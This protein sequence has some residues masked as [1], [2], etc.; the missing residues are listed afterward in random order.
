MASNKNNVDVI[1][2]DEGKG[3]IAGS[4][5]IKTSEE[6]AEPRRFKKDDMISCRSVTYGELLFPG[7]KSQ[8]L[9]TW[10]DCGDTTEVE[11]Q[12]LQALRSVRSQYLYNPCFVI[13]DEDLI[14]QW[15]DLKVLYN[16]VAEADIHKL[17][18]LPI[19]KFEQAL[20]NIPTG[21]K[22]AV[23][24]AASAKIIDGSLDSIQKIRILDNILG[25][26]LKLFIQ[27]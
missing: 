26:E 21:Y 4:E 6:Q 22:D 17:F 16:K 12:D 9:Y 3:T 27:Q 14:E 1:D 15:S 11:Y 13:E 20:K 19:K 24:N 18:D 10:A 23:K 2:T 7:K 8:L 25:T 5:E